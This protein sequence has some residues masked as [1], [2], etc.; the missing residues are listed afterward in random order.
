MPPSP[1][2]VEGPT[3]AG[4]LRRVVVVGV[5]SVVAVVAA[6][7]LGADGRRLALTTVG[8]VLVVAGIGAAA[9]AAAVRRFGD[10]QLSELAR[11]Y[12]TTTYEMG[13]WWLGAAPGGPLTVG[14]V[15]WD[16]TGTWI[17][18]PSGEVVEP[19]RPDRDPP[20]LYPSPRGGGW[21]VWTG[22]QWTGYVPRRLQ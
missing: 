19:P 15:Q 22:H 21:E 13:R 17:L 12:T 4:A 14:W 10:V 6:V 1:P 7:L 9:T 3:A 5:A 8:V 20:G 18:R 2:R 11:G 16:W